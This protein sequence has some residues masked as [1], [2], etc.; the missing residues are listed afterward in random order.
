MDRPRESLPPWRAAALDNALA[1]V[2]RIAG[3]V[4]AFPHITKGRRWQTTP[5]G[6]W[7]GGFWAGLLWLAWA[8][9]HEDD[10]LEAARRATDRLL[11]RMHDR[12]NHDLGFMFYPSA[13]RGFRLT[14]ETRYRDAAITAARSLALQFN[15]EGGYIPGWGFFG[16]AE[17]QGLVLIDTLMNLP[18]LA[19]AARETG[20]D[21][22]LDV[23]HR[24]AA[25][26]LRHQLRADGSVYHMFR[27]DAA[28]GVPLGGDTYQGAGPDS[29]WTRGQ[30]WA[31]T[32]LAILG[33][34][35][36]DALYPAASARIANYFLSSLAPDGIPPWDF[37]DGRPD[38][39]RDASAAAIAAYGLI[40]LGH[41][42][43]DRGYHNQAIRLLEALWLRCANH[44]EQGGLLLH[45]TADL[46]HGLGVDESTV[47]GD[48]YYVK[49][50]A[51]LEG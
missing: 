2:R 34:M 31:F 14:G 18:L 45:A 27:F 7:T 49:A 19:W 29:A 43:G 21:S 13:V 9:R 46:P 8:C 36:G 41:L 11:P 17:W 32:G 51:A 50:L 25:T 4:T 26:S 12:H 44:G 38:A 10:C 30:A 5:D 47:Y 48:Y 39:P 42:T 16:G 22:L 15:D 35:T 37:H 23:A 20:D 6:V 33:A 1:R 40:R 28:S 3:E 24:H